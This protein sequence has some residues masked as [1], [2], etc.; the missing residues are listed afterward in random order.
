MIAQTSDLNTYQKAIKTA[1]ETYEQTVNNLY[2]EMQEKN[3]KFIDMISNSMQKEV[4]KLEMAL[5]DCKE[6]IHNN[7]PVRL[8][9]KI[10]LRHKPTW[11]WSSNENS[12][13]A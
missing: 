9:E 2:H 12:E 4:K 1:K 11:K 8:S 3:A 7:I 5:M 6:D 13:I 10:I